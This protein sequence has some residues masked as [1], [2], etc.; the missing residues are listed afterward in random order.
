MASRGR[1][2][3]C[4]ALSGTKANVLFSH[5]SPCPLWRTRVAPFLLEGCPG[6]ALLGEGYAA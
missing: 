5:Q 3:I 4:S 1:A 6:S 2:G